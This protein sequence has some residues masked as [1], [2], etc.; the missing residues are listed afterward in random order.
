MGTETSSG[1]GS[2]A[3]QPEGLLSETGQC[4]VVV[5]LCITGADVEIHRQRVGLIRGRF[6]QVNSDDKE[7]GVVDHRI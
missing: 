3:R 1:C 7:K 4:G 6:C 5:F 2:I